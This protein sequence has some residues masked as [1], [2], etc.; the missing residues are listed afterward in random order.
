MQDKDR[1]WEGECG[2]NIMYSLMCEDEKM[3]PVETL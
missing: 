2:R 1:E 3:R